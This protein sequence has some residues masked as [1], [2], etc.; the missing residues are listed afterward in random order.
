M[1]LGAIYE[2]ETLSSF[3]KFQLYDIWDSDKSLYG[4][5]HEGLFRR[6]VLFNFCVMVS[7]IEHWK[8]KFVAYSGPTSPEEILYH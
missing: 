8:I 4:Y 1:F 3:L 2:I 6:N 7:W 5:F